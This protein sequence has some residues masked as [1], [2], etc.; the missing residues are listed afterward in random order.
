M[1]VLVDRAEGGCVMA[2]Q[3]VRAVV[4]KAAAAVA[5]EPAVDAQEIARGVFAVTRDI[6]P[7]VKPGALYWQGPLQ[8]VCE[9]MAGRV[10]R[11]YGLPAAERENVAGYLLAGLNEYVVALVGEFDR[12]HFAAWIAAQDGRS[13]MEAATMPV[14]ERSLVQR[15]EAL[16][17]ANDV[18]SRRAVLKREVAARQ[19]PAHVV[20]LEPPSEAETMK[21]FD[22]LL[23]MP[24]IGRVKAQKMLAQVKVSP[25]KTVGGLSA[26]QRH[27]LVQLLPRQRR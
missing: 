22:L 11:Q 14:P 25:S 27:E 24:K 16:K 20:L 15:M 9:Q 8:F 1:R 2:R 26:R 7:H 6:A 18:R 13:P 3:R 5:R 19:R 10:V 12:D 4:R 21:V 17:R 23:A